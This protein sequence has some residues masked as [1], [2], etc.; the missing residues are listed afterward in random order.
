MTRYGIRHQTGA[1]LIEAMVALA[2]L[3]LVLVGSLTLLA[4]EERAARRLAARQAAWAAIERTVE[5]VRGGALP[6]A[7]QVST[8]RLAVPGAGPLDRLIVS[9]HVAPAEPPVDLYRVVVQA[10]WEVRGE[11]HRRRVET[12]VWKPGRIRV[13]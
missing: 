7:P 5:A 13:R 8:E 4:V 10:R 6:L 9:V 2:L 12:L 11:P 1:T 3:G